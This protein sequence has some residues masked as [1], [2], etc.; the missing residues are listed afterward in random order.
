MNPLTNDNGW[1]RIC[2]LATAGNENQLCVQLPSLTVTNVGADYYSQSHVIYDTQGCPWTATAINLRS[3]TTA[4]THCSLITSW[5]CTIYCRQHVPSTRAVNTCRDSRTP[6]LWRSQSLRSTFFF[7]W[8]R[9]AYFIDGSTALQHFNMQRLSL[10]VAPIP[11]LRATAPWI[12][13]SQ[14]YRAIA[15]AVH[16]AACNAGTPFANPEAAKSEGQAGAIFVKK[17]AIHLWIPAYL[18]TKPQYDINAARYTEPRRAYT[19]ETA[20]DSPDQVP[21]KR[22]RIQKAQGA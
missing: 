5:C 7:F 16:V 19:N 6:R 15:T 10:R 11:T 8:T 12:R 21:P 4:C 2:K 3:E 17:S 14:C 1:S 18:L 22:P 9:D 13:A 20:W